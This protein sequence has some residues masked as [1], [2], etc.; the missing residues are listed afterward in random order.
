MSDVLNITIRLIYHDYCRALD[1]HYDENERHTVLS[2][3]LWRA[4][5]MGYDD[6]GRGNN[7]VPCLFNSRAQLRDAWLLGFAHAAI[8]DSVMQ[9]RQRQCGELQH[10][11]DLQNC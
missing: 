11:A 5:E 8:H 4:E 6:Y 2:L 10:A 3:M 1:T 7:Q 9:L